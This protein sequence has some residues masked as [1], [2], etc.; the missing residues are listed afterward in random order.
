MRVEIVPC[1]QDNYAYVVV[2]PETGRAAVIDQRRSQSRSGRRSRVRLS[3]CS[4]R[5]LATSP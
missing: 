3:A 5:H 1:L 4:R 2:C